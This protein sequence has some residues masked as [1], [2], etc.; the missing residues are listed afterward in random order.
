MNPQA[1]WV[2]ALGRQEGLA[3]ADEDIRWVVGEI[4]FNR[5]LN[6][7][8]TLERASLVLQVCK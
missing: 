6:C 2:V 1:T 4:T 7:I 3:G 5:C 8:G